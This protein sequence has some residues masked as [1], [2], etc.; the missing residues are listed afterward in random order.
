MS[1][2]FPSTGL[3]S[4]WIPDQLYLPA[5]FLCR[6]RSRDRSELK[7]STT[8]LPTTPTSWRFLRARWSWWTERRT[9]SGGW[10][11]LRGQGE[12]RGWIVLLFFFFLP[13]VSSSVDPRVRSSCSLFFLWATPAGL[14]VF[15]QPLRVPWDPSHTV[16]TLFVSSVSEK[17]KRW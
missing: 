15:S 17:T 6:L 1:F 4:H 13:A 2:H 14:T 10:V 7:P 8:A 16:I 9:R 3:T 11:S 5:A 12:V